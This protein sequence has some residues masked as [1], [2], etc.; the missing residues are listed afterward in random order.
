LIVSHW[1]RRRAHRV[2]Y[3]WWIVAASIG[4]QTITMGLLMQAYGAYVVVMQAEFGW[5]RTAF[6]VAFSLQRV[7]SGLLGPL[8]GWL[9][10]RFGPRPIMTVG[11]I[12]FGIG[13][14]LFSQINSLWTFYAVF[15]LMAVGVS[16]SGFM[17]IAATVINW[18]SRLRSTAMGIVHVGLGIGGLIVPAVA[19][20]LNT[21][22][23]RTTAF[24]SGVI[25]L[26]IG[27]PLAQLFRH[28]PEQYGWL[29]DGDEV[30]KTDEEG[31]DAPRVIYDDSGDFTARQA[32]RT[33]A[34]WLISLG[35][36]IGVMV[37][38]IV[39]VHAIVH[40]NEGL[41]YSLTVGA[42]VIAI[43]TAVSIV[44]NLIGG[45]LGDRMSKRLLASICMLASGGA[46]LL[47]GLAQTFAMVL[48]F[49]II[50]GLA[51][52]VRGV[53]MQPMRAD[54]FGRK[55]FATIMGFS[56]MIV[57]WGMTLGPI[58]AGLMADSLGDYRLAFMILGIF[59]AAGSL[60]FAF[61]RRPVHPSE[62]RAARAA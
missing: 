47:L 60:C 2:F 45:F 37:V 13:F 33:P 15:L 48:A 4:I 34:F 52:G 61:A 55:A 17:S 42:S 27:V 46:L 38:G 54:Y 14:M 58:I 20:S 41:G 23:W 8:Q 51:H 32:M 3:G 28:T 25:I 5:S 56:S 43:L 39:M 9:L 40:M 50:Q 44:G 7:E 53:L 24:A 21:F 59:V 19:W 26:V 29:P 30:E 12:I 22:G 49:A 36:G 11:M 18:F 16:L 35:H 31:D 1:V 62:R 57:M 10:D 6:S